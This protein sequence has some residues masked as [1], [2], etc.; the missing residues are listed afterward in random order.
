MRWSAA[1]I[2]AVLVL[3][4]MVGSGTAGAAE[5]TSRQRSD[6]ASVSAL[7]SATLVDRGVID[8][9]SNARVDRRPLLVRAQVHQEAAG[10]KHWRAMIAQYDSVGG[11]VTRRPLLPPQSVALSIHSD[12]GTRRDRGA[13]RGKVPWATLRDAGSDIPVGQSV[14]LCLQSVGSRSGTQSGA[15]T[16]RDRVPL[17]G[18][19]CVSVIRRLHSA[20]RVANA[21]VTGELTGVRVSERGGGSHSMTFGAASVAAFRDRPDP[22]LQPTIPFT[23]LTRRKVWRRTFGMATPQ[24]QMTR[25]GS[26][27]LVAVDVGRPVSLG[28]GRYRWRVSASDAERLSAAQVRGRTLTF[29]GD[30]APTR[31]QHQECVAPTKYV[32]QDPVPVAADFLGEVGSVSITARPNRPYL[33]LRADRPRSF[34]WFRSAPDCRFP[35]VAATDFASL[36][37]EAAWREAFGTIRPNSSLVWRDGKGGEHVMTFEQQRP[38]WDAAAKTWTSRVRP[39][40]DS[41]VPSKESVRRFIARY[42]RELQLRSADLYVDST[43]SATNGGEYIIVSDDGTRAGDEV[44]A[45]TLFVVDQDF[46]FDYIVDTTTQELVVTFQIKYIDEGWFGLGYHAFMFPS[47]NFVGSWNPAEN[48]GQFSYFDGYNPGIPTLPF[49][50][51]PAPDTD[52]IFVSDGSDIFDNQNNYTCEET[53]TGTQFRTVECRR[54]LITNDIFDI[55]F[56]IDGIYPICAVYNLTQGFYT[57]TTDISQPSHTKVLCAEMALY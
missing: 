48:D 25:P 49:F 46:Q 23:E 33:T 14:L 32:R 40:I 41:V 47:D 1:P 44:S 9:A 52:P 20:Q 13:L 8:V 29:F 5:P 12:A 10:G 15:R 35:L 6:G 57:S 7:V 24:F 37:R 31:P 2:S 19:D 53:T 17:D 34:H 36:S 27:D 39:L 56:K 18:T 38:R 51:A 54:K 3:T 50:P 4:S 11:R 43:N 26:A 55:Q 16:V 22:S 30:A 28:G 21:L 42:G 45:S